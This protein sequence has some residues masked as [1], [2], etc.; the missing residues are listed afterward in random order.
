M[1]GDDLTQF[2]PEKAFF[3]F[4]N[5]EI[6]YNYQNN[7]KK[8]DEVYENFKVIYMT[9]IVK[10]IIEE[11]PKYFTKELDTEKIAKEIVKGLI[12]KLEEEKEITRQ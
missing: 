7:P 4:F 11:N 6:I 5:P 10:E 12:K 3:R 9:S 2:I 8:N 1:L